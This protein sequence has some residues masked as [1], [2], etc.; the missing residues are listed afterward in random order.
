MYLSS[1]IVTLGKA[2]YAV[3]IHVHAAIYAHGAKQKG[4][5]HTNDNQLF[6]PFTL[7]T[8]NDYC[9]HKKVSLSSC[10]QLQSDVT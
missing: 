6:M 7:L 5:W 8:K 10:Y 3:E 4:W 1:N 9:K 2:D